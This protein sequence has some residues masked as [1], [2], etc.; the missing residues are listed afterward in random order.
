MTSH[1]VVARI[2]RI[3]GIK[4]VG[5]SGTL[6]PNA[7]G[8]LPICIGKSTR[9]SEYLLNSDKVYMCEATLGIRTDTYD[10]YGAIVHR[11]RHLK[12]IDESVVKSVLKSFLGES[13]QAPPMY[14]ALKINGKKLYEYAR[15]GQ[16]IE[17]KS[18]VINIKSIELITY[19]FPKLTFKTHVSKGTYIRTL[20][21]DIG[22]ALGTYACMSWLIRTE[23][24]GLKIEDS[25]TLTELEDM[26]THRNNLFLTSPEKVLGFKKITFVEEQIIKLRNGMSI[27]INHGL[28][29]E[30]LFFILDD[31]STLWGIGEVKDKNIVKMRKLLI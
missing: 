19:D 1:D 7:A 11:D 13:L 30:D 17:V 14:S 28:T 15:K 8:V 4:K 22:L 29:R 18:R 16:E 2:R 10:S 26:I 21:N 3:T 5:H 23:S 9:L 20:C 24:K 27:E 6:D 31:Q 25:Y 12:K